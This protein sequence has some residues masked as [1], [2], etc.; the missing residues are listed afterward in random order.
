LQNTENPELITEFGSYNVG[1]RRTSVTYQPPGQEAARTLPVIVWYPSDETAGRKDDLKLAKVMKL[2]TSGY[3][4]L[5]LAEDG[6]FPV[7]VHS[8]GSGGEA[9]LAYPAAEVFAS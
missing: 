7:V 1:V 8:H 3:R 5:A 6:P 4:N 2:P 9:S